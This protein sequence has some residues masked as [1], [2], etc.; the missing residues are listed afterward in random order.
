MKFSTRPKVWSAAARAAL[1]ASS[2]APEPVQGGD[3]RRQLG[4][5]LGRGRGIAAGG[6]EIAPARDLAAFHFLRRD[7]RQ[8]RRHQRL[9]I[10]QLRRELLVLALGA[11]R[12]SFERLRQL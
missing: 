8:R 6:V 2:V 5:K 1:R 12:Q 4:V 3:R 9:G 10:R 11:R 7:P